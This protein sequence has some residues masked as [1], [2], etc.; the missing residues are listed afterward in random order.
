MEILQVD[1]E[2]G[3]KCYTRYDN[4]FRECIF[5]GT[6][7][8]TDGR[9]HVVSC[10]VLNIAGIGIRYV[11][12]DRFGQFNNWYR[13]TTC[14]TTLYKTV[15]D[16]MCKRNPIMAKYGDTENCYNGRF[17]E[18]FFPECSVCNCGGSIYGWAWDGTDAIEV[19][20]RL[21]SDEYK[22]DESGFHKVGRV[23]ASWCVGNLRR[24]CVGWGEVYRTK[25]ECLA[26]NKAEIVTF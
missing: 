15:D 7:G 9:N 14:N 6:K 12:F 19:G 20:C 23:Q 22:I 13:G 11:A 1:Y 4:A 17:M 18:Q 21:T 24:I 16:C 2:I 26:N 10:Y 25:E 5:M 8:V 3:A